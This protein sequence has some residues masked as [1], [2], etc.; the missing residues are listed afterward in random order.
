[1]EDTPWTFGPYGAEIEAIDEFVEGP[2][3][4][5]CHV[6]LFDRVSARQQS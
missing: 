2:E 3:V 6:L 5:P 1:M 4:V